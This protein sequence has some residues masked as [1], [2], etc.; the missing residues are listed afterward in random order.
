MKIRKPT[1][2]GAVLAGVVLVLSLGLVP[3]AFAGK[4]HQPTSGSS[5]ISG[6]AWSPTTTGTAWPN[7][8]DTVTFNDVDDSDGATL[9]PLGVPRER[10]RLRQLEGRFRRISRHELELR[11]Q[12]RRLDRVGAGD[13]TACSACTRSRAS[14]S[15]RPRASMSTHRHSFVACGRL[16]SE[17]AARRPP[18]LF[19]GTQ[20]QGSSG[21]V[22]VTIL[23]QHVS[24]A[25]VRSRTERRTPVLS[26]IAF[27]LVAVS[28]LVFAGAAFGAKPSGSSSITG[29]Y[30]VTAS[31]TP[32][33]GDGRLDN[34][35]TLR[36]HG[37]V[38]HLHPG[39]E[40]VREP[41]LLRERHRVQQLGD[42]L[43]HRRIVR[44]QFGRMD[45]R[46]GRL[47][48]EPRHVREQQQVQGARVDELPRG[49]IAAPQRSLIDRGPG[50]R[51]GLCRFRRVA[52]L[53]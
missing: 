12:L 33:P 24:F 4:G 48:G 6:P 7:W 10:H 51:R 22:L 37:Y 43:A 21:A 53:R 14:I 16:T 50:F 26:K 15:S 20:H 8:G 25:P 31:P 35:A 38:R 42:L 29:P 47:H 49:R 1:P 19:R 46:S 52:P 34:H 36:R 3:A 30:L 44:S 40:P 45:E 11:A 17:R 41:H 27:A 5:S 28:V 9:C 2:A 18:F 32:V 23:T 39:G 13:C